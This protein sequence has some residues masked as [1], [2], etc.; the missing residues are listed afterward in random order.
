MKHTFAGTI[1]VMAASLVLTGGATGAPSKLAFTGELQQVTDASIA[2][3]L[4]D[5]RIIEARNTATGGDLSPRNLAKLYT[6][7]DRVEIT[8]A[9]IGGVYSPLVRRR[10]SI[11]LKKLRFLRAP[12]REE[13]SNA[14]ASKAWRQS[15]NLL[16]VN[17]DPPSESAPGESLP[18]PLDQI[19][20]HILKF[21]SEMPNFVADEVAKRYVSTTNPPN[22]RLADTIESEITFKG[23]AVS[24]EHITVDGKPWNSTYRELP[25]FKWT[26]AFGSQLTHLFDPACLTTFEPEGKSAVRYNSPPDGCEF[27]WQDYQQFYPGRTGRILLDEG[28][29]NVIRL[30][31]NSE[32]FPE[33]F[34]ISSSEKQVSWDFVKIGDATRLL[35]VS[36]EIQIALST[37]EM[38][39]ARHEYKNHRHFEAASNVTFH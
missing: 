6:V 14:L 15:P 35:P 21:V 25:G 34:P 11:E 2:I 4:A 30:E 7:G 12:S 31:T 3:R 18:P 27:F 16:K 13:R 32:V 37:G 8:C 38:R 17:V 23:I 24:R 26:D 36:A 5:G 19:R 33:A 9:A 39:L 22:W 29:Q 10:L 20:S 1:L 28:E